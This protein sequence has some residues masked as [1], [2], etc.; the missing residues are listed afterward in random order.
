MISEDERKR[1]LDEIRE[2][3]AR[4]GQHI[5]CVFGGTSPR[6]AYTIGVSD[7]VGVELI[8]A[9][10]ILYM[11]DEVAKIILKTVAHL[12]SARDRKLVGIAGLGSFTLREVDDSWASEL[13]LGVFDYYKR[14][15]P[16]LQIVPDQ[17]HITID[18]PNMSVPFSPSREPVW[19]WLRE[20]WPYPVRQDSEAITD[21][22][23]L[24][25]ARI[26]EACRWEEEEWELFAR[27]GPDIPKD[28]MRIVALG[29]L[30]AADPS[31]EPIVNLTIG[32][33]MWRDA[34]SEWHPWT[35]KR[36]A[37]ED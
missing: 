13:M 16:A 37:G 2:N 7:S 9:G 32:T 29:T 28:E 11:R 24:R 35:K 25:G 5:Y 10:A 4:N 14:D 22:A 1:A 18:V 31:L 27:E 23:A 34:S 8:F 20:A 3:I 12:K 19:K 36:Q 33:G 21:L 6:F 26:T 30:L 15:V 17:D